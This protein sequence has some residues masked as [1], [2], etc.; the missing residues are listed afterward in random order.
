MRL[1]NLLLITTLGALVLLPLTAAAETSAAAPA[2]ACTPPA[3]DELT[4]PLVEQTESMWCWAATAEMTKRFLAGSS[5]DYKQCNQV[6]QFLANPA[7]D[8]CNTPAH[9]DCLKSGW[10]QY[11][12][13]FAATCLYE[14]KKG[15]QL[16]G[17][18][19]GKLDWEIIRAEIHCARRP[20]VFAW[21][22][23]V[24][25]GGHLMVIIGYKETADGRFLLVNDSSP[26]ATAYYMPFQQYRGGAG[27][28]YEHWRD[29]YEITY[30]GP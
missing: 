26:T 1:I 11:K 9:Q 27:Y 29:Y 12:P 5:P 17:C 19:P 23:K 22:Y 21:R 15:T 25:G 14:L 24:S 16:E 13:P 30:S 6:N 20:I 3:E 28:T 7:I 2:S 8:C 10:P 18:A 4:V